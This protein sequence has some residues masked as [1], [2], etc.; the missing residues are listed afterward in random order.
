MWLND[1]DCLMLRDPLTLDQA[2]VWGSLLALSGQLNVVSE[3]LP[4]LPPEK[5]D[6]VKRTMPNHNGLG[7]PI[8][9][10]ANRQPATWH[11]RGLVGRER[12]DLVA[13]I[14]WDEKAPARAELDLAKIGL[15]AGPDDRYVGFDYWEDVFVE[16]FAER[17]RF[18]LRP[19]SCRV[20]AVHRL[21]DHPQL[22]STSRHVTQGVVDVV[23]VAWDADRGTLRGRSRLV[24][25]DPYELRIVTPQGGSRGF[26]AVSAGVSEAD[27]KAGVTVRLRQEGPKVRVMIDGPACREVAWSV[28]FR[29]AL[30][31][32]PS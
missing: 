32:A 29:R 25:G 24:G 12:V 27:Q 20:I 30:P 19:S 21:S 13:L 16:P 26:Q 8:D 7:R 3:W 1:P 2:R 22:V 5:L 23:E 15:P 4:G 11:Y 10:F 6:V 9:L 31:K 14:N 28:G 17:R 18:D